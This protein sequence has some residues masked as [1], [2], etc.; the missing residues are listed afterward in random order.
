MPSSPDHKRAFDGN[1]GPNTGG[2]GAISPSP[3]YTPEVA[4]RC[5][6]EIFRPTVAALRAEGRPFQGVLYFGLMLTPQGPRVVEYNARFGDPECQAVLS[7]LETDLMAIFEA[8]RAGTLNKLEIRWKP[9]A[10][11]CLV[12][13]SGGY[14]NSYSR[15]V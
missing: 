6:E 9:A 13:A 14:P 7:L 10:A 8:C 2:M 5:M 11:C 4:A 1:Q 15:C 12:L 3:N